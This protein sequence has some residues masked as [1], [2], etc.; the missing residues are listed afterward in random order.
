[1]GCDLGRLAL[2]LY[3]SAEG[4]CHGRA[5]EMFVCQ[6]D[7]GYFGGTQIVGGNLAMGAGLALAACLSG[8]APSRPQRAVVAF[9]GDGGVNQGVLYEV[10]NLAAIWALPL[11]VVV[12]DN[13]YAQTTSTD[14]S[15]AGSVTKRA[16]GYDIAVG[17]VDGQVATEVYRSFLAAR[18]RATSGGG[19]TV[20][21]AVTYRYEGHFYG[22]RHRRYRSPAEVDR[23]R[24]R[25]PLE[26]H[27]SQLLEAGLTEGVA[28][29]AQESARQ[30]CA[31]AFER[32]RQGRPITFRD[33]EGDALVDPWSGELRR[34]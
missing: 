14:Y 6:P 32:A 20:L 1:M 2:E 22:D 10:L 27:R 28:L 16:A 31:E 4:T 12:E 23:W 5:G 15:T 26:I 34:A 9:V 33:V 29:E 8:S 19:P 18:E 3:G 21:R 24:A 30:R 7:V 25:D 11:I 17:E 13:G